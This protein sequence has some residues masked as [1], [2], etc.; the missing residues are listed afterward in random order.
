[1]LRNPFSNKTFVHLHC[2]SRP[3]VGHSLPPDSNFDVECHTL[4]SSRA[5]LLAGASVLSSVSLKA[6]A[7]DFNNRADSLES[8]AEVKYLVQKAME[9]ARRRRQK[10][11]GGYVWLN[12]RP[13][14]LIRSLLMYSAV[15]AG[16]DT[17]CFVPFL[18]H[19]GLEKNISSTERP[20]STHFYL[21]N[22][23]HEQRG[24]LPPYFLDHHGSKWDHGSTRML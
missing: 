22:A 14:I 7:S 12:I 2:N 5:D 17:F 9:Q 23:S 13:R 20:P 18:E 21:S 15:S 4:V 6:L 16:V 11:R 24:T 10:R 3:T 8:V 1:M 19:L